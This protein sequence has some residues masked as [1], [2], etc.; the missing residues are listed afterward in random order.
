[1]AHS[2]GHQIIVGVVVGLLVMI[3]AAW[4]RQKGFLFPPVADDDN[5]GFKLF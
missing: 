3:A 5:A 2:I 1:M 4:L